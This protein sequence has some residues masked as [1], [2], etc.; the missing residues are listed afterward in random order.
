MLRAVIDTGRDV[1][2][3]R[4][5]APR[6][7]ELPFHAARKM[8]TTV[9]RTST[10]LRAYTKGAPEAV[11][12]R[13]VG[14]LGRPGGGAPSFDRAELLR[15]AED[16]AADGYRVLAVACRDWPKLP[17]TRS[18]EKLEADLG[19]IGL[20]ALMD[21]PRPEAAEAVATCRDAG[22]VPIMITGDH[23]ATARAVAERLG[24]ARPGDALLNGQD[25]A[26]LSDRE[27]DA[28][29][30]DT[31]VSTHASRPSR[32]YGSSARYSVAVSS[33]R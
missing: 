12:A 33:S 23:P 18:S 22:I 6:V 14:R 19:F 3:L 2:A 29:V 21:P 16:L 32:R 4:G 28:L 26:A 25:L 9:H 20:V 31:P 10:G 1:E 27:L 24:I 11:T 17:A 8:M 7:A 5:A 13:C 30:A 15:Q